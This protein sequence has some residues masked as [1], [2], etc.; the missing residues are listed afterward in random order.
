[1]FAR[2]YRVVPLVNL[3]VA[4]TALGFQIRVLYPW[5]NG[6]R[7]QIKRNEIEEGALPK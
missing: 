1:M 4:S 6:T 3:V 2:W 5:P 7:R